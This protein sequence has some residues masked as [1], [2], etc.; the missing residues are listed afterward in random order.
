VTRQFAR[1][2]SVTLAAVLAV[3]CSGKASDVQQHGEKIDSLRATAV[4]VTTAWLAGDVSG[5]YA[6]AALE[7][8]FDLIADERDALASTPENLTLPAANAALNQSEALTRTVG[9]LWDAVRNAD[10]ASARRH[11]SELASPPA[12]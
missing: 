2:G 8:T 3:G 7:R 4:S 11:L 1:L 9:A 5:T 6:M 12:G 10:A